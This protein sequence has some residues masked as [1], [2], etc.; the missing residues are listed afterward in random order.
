M[1][2]SKFWLRTLGIAGILGSLI[3]FAGDMLFYYDSVETN[4]KV[5]MSNAADWRIKLSGITALFSVWFYLLGLIPTHYAFNKSSKTVKNL[6]LISFAAIL[7]AYGIIHGA[8]LAIAT[9][10]KLSAEYNLDI[11]RATALASQSNQLQGL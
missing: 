4:L 9:T 1:I 5:N 7:I 3:L 8:Y 11:E 2:T 10:S 6:L